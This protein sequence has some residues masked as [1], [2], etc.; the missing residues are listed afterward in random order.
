MN[1]LQIDTEGFDYEIIKSIAFDRYK[2]DIIIYEY[3]H[4]T[5]YQ[6]FACIE[7]LQDK[8]YLLWKNTD[9]FDVVALNSALV[10]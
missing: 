3:L 5:L 4:L 7:F 10:S 2:P 6:N 8:G 9:S 1:I